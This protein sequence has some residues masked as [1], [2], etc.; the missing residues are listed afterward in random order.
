VENT[1]PSRARLGRA[2]RRLTRHEL[3]EQ[4]DQILRFDGE[5]KLNRYR[6]RARELAPIVGVRLDQLAVLDELIGTALGTGDAQ[7]LPPVLHA[8]R[9]LRPFDPD[10]VRLFTLLVDALRE[11]PPQLRPAEADAGLNLPFFEAYF[12]NYIEGTEFTVDEAARIVF[13]HYAPEGRSEDAHDIA[14]TFSVVSDVVEMSRL[15]VNAAE[16]LELLR[17]RHAEVMA[18]RPD[19]RPGQLKVLANQAGNTQFVHPSLVEGTLTEGFARLAELDTA[20]ERSVYTM[21]LVAEVHPFDDG[22]GRLARI[23]MNAELVAKNEQRIIVPTVFRDD[24]L[25]ALRRLSRQEDPSVLIKALRY[26]QDWTSRIDWSDFDV[27]RAQI[28]ATNAF[29]PPSDGIRLLL[30]PATMFGEPAAIET[31]GE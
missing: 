25:G 19:K 6:D 22:N 24:Y 9:Y 23:M 30:P 15:A 8:R 29:E 26:A 27:A 11:A 21:F 18:G 20:W 4:I 13:E 12:S 1:V 14:G 10:R 16:F 3:G 17:A 2:P 31:N 5:E 7:D 28:S